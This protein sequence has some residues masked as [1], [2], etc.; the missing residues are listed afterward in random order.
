MYS[1]GMEPI[2]PRTFPYP[3][4]PTFQLH[5]G[6]AVTWLRSFTEG[7]VDLII[8][9]P[10][11]NIGKDFGNNSDKQTTPDYLE[12][13]DRFFWAVGAD[14]PTAILPPETGLILAD[15]YDA[16]ILR[17]GPE[18]PLPGA[19]RRVMVQKFARHAAARLQGLRDPGLVFTG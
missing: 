15:A 1:N 13:C 7:S 14:F 16:E 18:T 17:M 11:Y 8:T 3:T 9:D 12:W 19:R 10:P 2:V 6:D 5:Q 4:L